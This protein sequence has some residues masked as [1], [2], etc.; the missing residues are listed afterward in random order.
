MAWLCACLMY[1]QHFVIFSSGDLLSLCESVIDGSSVVTVAMAVV[2]GGEKRGLRPMVGSVGE[3]SILDVASEETLL[4]EGHSVLKGVVSPAIHP[5]EEQ[6]AVC[7][8]GHALVQVEL[9][10][11]LGTSTVFHFIVSFFIHY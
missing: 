11:L 1:L 4:G 6:G 7:L 9:E 5:A 10:E 3:H 2:S 8:L